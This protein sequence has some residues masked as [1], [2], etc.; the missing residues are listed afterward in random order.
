MTTYTATSPATGKTLTIETGRAVAYAV[1]GYRPAFTAFN[2]IAQEVLES[3]ELDKVLSFHA[4]RAA[5]EKKLASLNYGATL[6]TGA[7]AR[8]AHPVRRDIVKVVRA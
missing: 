4:T 6:G 3:A 7:A 5:A 8:Q 1:V 2:E